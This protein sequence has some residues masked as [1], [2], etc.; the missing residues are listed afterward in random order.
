MYKKPINFSDKILGEVIVK[1]KS[2]ILETD[3]DIVELV[4]VFNDFF[5]KEVHFYKKVDNKDVPISPD[6]ICKA[7]KAIQKNAS[8][9]EVTNILYN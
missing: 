4:Q 7:F 5:G 9:E 2:I 1:I 3:K 8:R 6:N